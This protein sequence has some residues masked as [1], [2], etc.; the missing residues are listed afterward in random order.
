MD[1]PVGQLKW[2]WRI[3]NYASGYGRQKLPFW[4]IKSA[5]TT[6][7][8]FSL[9]EILPYDGI[10]RAEWILYWENTYWMPG[11][12][13][14]G[15]WFGYYSVKDTVSWDPKISGIPL[16]LHWVLSKA[17]CERDEIFRIKPFQLWV[18]FEWLHEIYFVEDT[19]LLIAS[20][21]VILYLRHSSMYLSGSSFI[22]GDW[23]AENRFHQ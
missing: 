22:K 3:A 19:K 20:A 8:S 9:K 21:I 23:S 17:K 13:N 18:V 12:E 7:R 2:G 6:T 5:S 4:L 16:L 14:E 11:S 10:L 15:F 1:V